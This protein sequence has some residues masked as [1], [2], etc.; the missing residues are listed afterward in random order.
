MKINKTNS[1]KIRII[2]TISELKQFL[3]VQQIMQCKKVGFKFRLTI[4]K[5]KYGNNMSDEE[6]CLNIVII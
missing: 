4:N 3:I 5:T 6:F 1:V 2:K